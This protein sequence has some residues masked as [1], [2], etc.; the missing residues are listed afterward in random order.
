[1]KFFIRR[2]LALLTIILLSKLCN[3]QEKQF[4]TRIRCPQF[5]KVIHRQLR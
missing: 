4:I 5:Q 2:S 1:M 3:A